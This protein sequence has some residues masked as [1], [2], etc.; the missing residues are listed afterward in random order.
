MDSFK[1]KLDDIRV[2]GG[3]DWPEAGLDG[4]MQAIVC[5]GMYFYVIMLFIIYF[6]L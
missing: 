6:T 3:Y 2:S 1:Q 5:K 4:I